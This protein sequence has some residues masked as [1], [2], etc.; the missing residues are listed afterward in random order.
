MESFQVNRDFYNFC[1]ISDSGLD[2][3][4]LADKLEIFLKRS[5]SEEVKKS[6][7]LYLKNFTR[8]VKEKKKKAQQKE[9]RF[10]K[11]EET[12][13]NLPI[14]FPDGVTSETVD[15][16]HHSKR[17]SGSKEFSS[18]SE[19]HKRRRTQSLMALSTDELTFATKRSLR[20]VGNKA[21]SQILDLACDCSEALHIQKLITEDA[22]Q[23]QYTPDEALALLMSASLTKAQYNM[24]RNGA[25]QKG[26]SNLYPSYLQVFN[27]K[28][29]CFPENITVNEKGAKVDLQK[30]LEHT[31]A[32]LGPKQIKPQ[33]RVLK[34]QYKKNFGENLD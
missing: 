4:V 24:I 9:D 29:K 26:Y 11:Q 30:L 21:G 13:L 32:L 23:Q 8:R 5:F 20:S 12:W 27:A 34:R 22:A 16:G 25:K 19:R 28:K 33:K 7:K 14:S 17:D 10:L 6:L 18:F 2:P 31:S 15:F 3:N 1:S